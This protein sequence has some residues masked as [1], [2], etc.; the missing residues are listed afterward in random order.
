MSIEEAVE[1][2]N[3]IKQF[4]GYDKDSEIVKATQKSLDMAIKALET[5][6]KYKDAY[7]KGYEAGVK[8][9]NIDCGVVWEE[10]ID[11]IKAD[12]DKQYKWLMQTKQT[13]S[14]IDIAFDAIKSSI[15][16]HC[17]GDTE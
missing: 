16:K 3:A 5:I 14:D 13:L 15:D 8:A 4:I 11:A 1:R 12:I 7:N 17:G 10:R 6:P 9:T 2:L